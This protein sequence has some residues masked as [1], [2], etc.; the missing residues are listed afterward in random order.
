MTEFVIDAFGFCKRGE[1]LEGNIAV[2]KLDR[3][4]KESIDQAGALDWSLTGGFDRR[5]HSQLI[6]EVRGN[7]QLLCQRCLTPFSFELDSDAALILAS[8]E[9]SA[10]EIDA[11]LDDDSMEVIVGSTSMN[12]LQ[13]VEDEALLALP[14][15]PRHEI[16]P[17]QIAVEG[18]E[19]SKRESPFAALKN[20]KQ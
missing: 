5:G 10:D 19:L 15:S 6:L 17:S 18:A 14:L 16:C 12:V 20:I 1:Y 11:L 9:K 3:L 4:A 13:V 2:A 7:V 8:D